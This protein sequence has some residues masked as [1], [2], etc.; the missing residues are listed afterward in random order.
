[1]SMSS[2]IL[3]LKFM[4]RQAQKQQ[5]SGSAAPS[6]AATVSA[7]AVAAPPAV[8]SDGQWTLPASG[9][10]RVAEARVVFTDDTKP[11]PSA[12]VSVLRFKQ[13]RRSFGSFNPRLE[14]KLGE[15][16]KE[17]AAA[18]AELAAAAAEEEMLRKQEAERAA[19]H[20]K[21]DA[22]EAAERKEAVSD[23]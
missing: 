3:G 20:A 14:K 10:A 17:K 6:A 9:G 13:G 2:K 23:D 11:E 5:K 19:L 7:A 8:Q 22:H 18:A 15:I 1:M 12:P 16:T 4:Q 21:A